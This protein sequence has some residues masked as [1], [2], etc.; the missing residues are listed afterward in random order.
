MPI[1]R[2]TWFAGRT[3]EQ[4]A[5][6]AKAITEAVVRIGKTSADHTTIVFEDTAKEDWASGGV[7]ASDKQ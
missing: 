7:L 1:I 4:K 6:L 2:V 5:E 3:K